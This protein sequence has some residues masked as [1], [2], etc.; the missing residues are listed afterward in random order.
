MKR[1][2]KSRRWISLLLA[3]VLAIPVFGAASANA[4]AN[5]AVAPASP[6]NAGYFGAKYPALA[7]QDHVFE[8]VTY[9]ELD[10]LLRNATT[11]AN[12]NYVILF[13][14]SWQPETQAAIGYINE[15]AK[16]YGVTSI[17]NFDTRL[18]GPDH[19]LDIT[20]T[21]EHY[22]DFTRRYVDLG[23]RYLTNLN[24]HTSGDLGTL[25]A[26]YVTTN[27]NGIDYNPPGGAGTKTVNIAEAPFLFIYNKGNATAPIVASLEGIGDGGIAALQ[28]N[29]GAAYKTALRGVFDTISDPGTKNAHFKALTNQEYIPGSY[30]EFRTA[31]NP[32]PPAI[33]DETDPAA[34]IDSVTLDELKYVLGQEGSFAVFIGCAWCGDSQGIVKYLNQVASEYGVDKVYNWDFKLDGGVGGLTNYTIPT[35]PRYAWG[36][37]SGNYTGNGLHTRTNNV[38]I[39]HVFTDFVNQFLPNLTTE[40]TKQA[41]PSRI[42]GTNP[43][44]NE[45]VSSSRLQAPFIFVY[46]KR[47]YDGQTWEPILGHV[48]LMGYWRDT[49]NIADAKTFKTN[50]LRTLFSRIEWK[51]SA[52]SAVAPTEAGG[53]NGQITGIANKS[54]EYRLKGQPAY[55]AVPAAGNVIENL[56]PGV[57]EVRYAAKPGFDKINRT[58]WNSADA[59][60]IYDPSESVEITVPDFQAAPVGLDSVAPTEA[61]GNG[62]IVSIAN[63]EQQALPEGLEYKRED[64]PDTAYAAVVNDAIS[65]EPGFY[66][67]VR[68]AAKTVQGVYYAPSTAVTV[69]V[70]GYQELLPPDRNK[71]GVVHPTTLENNDG[72]ITGLAGVSADHPEYQLEYKKGDGE[73]A[74][75]PQEAITAGTLSQLTP[76]VYDVRYAAY[77]APN[78]KTFNPSPAV[79][80][81]I[82]GNVAAPTGLAGV[83]PTN[84]GQSNGKITGTNV[85]LEYRSVT[86]STYHPV[87]GTEIASLAPGNYQ[88]RYKETDSS[89]AS[90][91]VTITVPQYVAPSQPG[92]N[93]GGGGGGGGVTPTPELVTELDN[94]ARADVKAALDEASGT[95]LAAVPDNVVNALLEKAKKAESEGNDASLEIRIEEADASGNVQVTLTRGVFDTLVSGS[96][97]RLKIDVGFGSV[98]FDAEALS[99]IAANEDEGDISFIISKS[100]LT[101]EGK[102]ILGD[103]PV[104]DLLVFA[105]QSQVSSFGGSLVNVFLPY[106]PKRGED[107]N[108]LIVYYVNEDGELH[109]IEGKYNS[110]SNGVS[111]ATEH[112]S[113]YIIGYNKI[114]FEDVAS[115]SWYAPA[116]TFL[117]AREITS[118][119][120]ETHFSPNADITR[121]QFIVLLLNA[122]GIEADG[123]GADNFADAGNAYYTGYLAAAKRLGIANGYEGNRFAPN[124][125]ISRQEL[126][127]LLY[128]A[129]T[130]L[131]KLPATAVDAASL[132]DFSD[133]AEVAGYA[134]EALEALVKAGV[135][136]G[137]EGK[138]NPRD[139]STRAQVAQVLYNLLSK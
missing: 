40:N 5:P 135:V 87:T 17:K 18:A 20:K 14:G 122:Y 54:L 103:R 28:N 72:Q 139:E 112:F 26:E 25:S 75:I 83:A 128:R 29:N 10:Y 131:E 4:S 88:V 84:S 44:T 67:Q 79:A 133:T 82:K 56:S 16:E 49:Y 15:V 61:A 34:V 41:T 59:T 136:S 116:V 106:E 69:Y 96:K 115:S 125:T 78:D 121:G 76:G 24:E 92:G 42:S 30:N 73:Y 117:A 38:K 107:P 47:N 138:L 94:G 52:L 102:E 91:A 101:E 19:P 104:Y 68:Y 46:D 57:Y 53:S 99:A 86:E 50:S 32:V 22:G 105:G 109:L 123:E 80:L 21:S 3:A 55:T 63:G 33:F 118:G 48:E 37:G 9:Y 23:A 77:T 110:S 62:Q 114:E 81:T 137:S 35:N 113:Q 51:P 100:E 2:H 85:G 31:A 11:G 130:V 127:T 126:F 71:L 95:W 129:L 70:P 60:T 13:G 27:V 90:A 7:G 45:A 12:D 134:L 119:T 120:D 124:E 89:L 132:T 8:T 111:F 64:A 6:G 74:W 98:T 1:R 43:V 65:V 93:N 108:A 39:T 66:Y 36:D 58:T 97:A